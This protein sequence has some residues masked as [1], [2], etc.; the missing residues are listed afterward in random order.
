MCQH[1]DEEC[2]I[3][4]Y[5]SCAI[6]HLA[7]NNRA[8]PYINCIEDYMM[9]HNDDPDAFN[10]SLVKCS[11]FLGPNATRKIQ[12]AETAIISNKSHL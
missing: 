10:K 9:A 3:N 4:K 5:E 8:M 7:M 1:G 6:H 11:E 2:R 12:Y